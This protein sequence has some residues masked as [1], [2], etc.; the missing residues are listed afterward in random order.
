MEKNHLIRTIYLYLF[1]LVG[2]VLLVIGGVGLVNLGLKT[3]IFTAAYSD[4][5]YGRTVPMP[6]VTEKA[7]LDSQTSGKKVE[8]TAAEQQQLEYWLVDYKNWQETD[9]KVDYAKAQRQRDAANDIAMI[10]IGL[11][12]YLIHWSIIKKETKKASLA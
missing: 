5:Y 7:V 10:I 2:L 3:Y 8:V 1:S 6:A 9:S 12:L 4:Q 11:P